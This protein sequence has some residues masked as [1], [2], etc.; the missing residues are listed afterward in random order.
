MKD[1]AKCNN[2]CEL[3]NSV[4]QLTIERKSDLWALLRAC[5]CQSYCVQFVSHVPCMCIKCQFDVF[6]MTCDVQFVDY[7]LHNIASV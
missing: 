3:Q 4:N 5:L 2:H 7:V 1:A 6:V